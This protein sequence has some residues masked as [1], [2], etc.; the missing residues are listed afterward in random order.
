MGRRRTSWQVWLR[1]ASQTG[2]T[3][4]FFWLFLETVYKPVNETGR[5]IKFF[6]QLDPLIL[7]SSWLGFWQVTAGLTLG[8]IT[9]GV[10]FI[11]GRWF[12]GWVCP[13]GAIHN[14]ITSWSER[15]AKARID[16]GGYSRWQK[17]K[18][19]VLIAVL[20]SAALGLNLAGWIDPFSFLYRSMATAVYPAANDATKGV[21]TFLYNTDPGI[22]KARVTVV[23]E[24]V[25]G[26]LRQ[27]FIA[28]AQPHFDGTILIGV[29]FVAV[30]ALNFY[31]ARFWCRYICPAGA[32]LGVI[33]KNPLVRLER[34]ADACNNCG[35]CIRDC[36][37]GANP[38]GQDGWK[39]S[40]CFYCWNCHSACKHEAFTFSIL[41]AK[42]PKP[43]HEEVER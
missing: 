30:I 5:G 16:T 13:F 38:A 22:G 11:A 23:S 14:L 41:P 3:L 25:Y 31:R 2:F 42:T 27:H 15:R 32:L 39:P 8:L 28:A 9:A 33:G 40:E 43:E 10:T 6:F 19:Y 24:P 35:L 29:L 17:A 34:N 36:Q 7:V 18:Y 20:V 37:G 1:R 4:L 12:C 26:V 21:F